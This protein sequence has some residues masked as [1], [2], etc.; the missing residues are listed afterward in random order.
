MP[1]KMALYRVGQVL[2][3]YL[4]RADICARIQEQKIIGCWESVVG[5][6]IA[7][8]TQAVRVR[9]RVL[10]VKVTNSVWVQEL[11]FHKELILKKLNDSIRETP[12][13]RNYG[14]LSEKRS[15]GPAQAIPGARRGGK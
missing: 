12:G 4:N 13:C 9:N 8:V 10:Q 7:E 3:K 11:Q 1:K 6:G 5:K 2:E 14:F 15:R